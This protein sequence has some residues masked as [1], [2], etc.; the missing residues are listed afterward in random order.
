[1]AQE[2]SSRAQRRL[3]G[4][5]VRIRAVT[6]ADRAEIQRLCAAAHAES[7]MRAVPIQPDRV[8]VVID[9][10][11]SDKTVDIGMI[12]ES[13]RGG[14]VRAVGLLHASAA[15][16][17]YLDLIQANCLL[18]Y[19]S[20]EFRNSTAAYQLMRHFI[21][22]SVNSGAR[23]ISVHVSAGIRVRQADRFLRKMG[24]MNGGGNYQILVEAGTSVK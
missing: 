9:H 23:S 17:L 6:E 13:D 7:Y 8:D 18:F 16:H 19:V 20:P 22:R 24:F 3:S 10:V 5:S 11:L 21:R 14:E 12:A 15:E 2:R 1:M 4:G